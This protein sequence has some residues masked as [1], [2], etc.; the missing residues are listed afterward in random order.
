MAAEPGGKKE[1]GLNANRHPVSFG[2]DG[3]VLEL[4]SG[5]VS[6]ALWM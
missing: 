4:N 6:T 2:G 3:D 1:L 5:G